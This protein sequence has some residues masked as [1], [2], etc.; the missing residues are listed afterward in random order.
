MNGS[1]ESFLYLSKSKYR[2]SSE[3]FQALLVNFNSNNKLFRITGF[4]YYNNLDFIQYFEGSSRT[5]NQLKQNIQ[6][7]PRHSVKIWLNDREKRS[8]RFPDWSM[9]N[10]KDILNKT[11]SLNN[12]LNVMYSILLLS[13]QNIIKSGE[14]IDGR[15]QRKL[16]EKVDDLS[17]LVNEMTLNQRITH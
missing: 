9:H 8:R 1:L 2:L 5:V 12:T 11:D 15:T 17:F 14:K 10:L 6:L 13:L 3:E 16:F 7:D 4:L